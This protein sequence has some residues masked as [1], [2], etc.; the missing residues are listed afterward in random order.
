MFLGT[1]LKLKL[2]TTMDESV[3][4]RGVHYLAMIK[5]SEV[6]GSPVEVVAIVK[7]GVGPLSYMGMQGLVCRQNGMGFYTPKLSTDRI[8]WGELVKKVEAAEMEIFGDPLR[9]IGEVHSFQQ[10]ANIAYDAQVLTDP[11]G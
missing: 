1:F 2:G 6:F 8:T 7:G 9:L 3:V 5:S 4:L 10:V 11:E